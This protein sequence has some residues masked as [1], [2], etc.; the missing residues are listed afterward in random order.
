VDGIRMGKAEWYRDWVV[1][2][3]VYI[4]AILDGEIR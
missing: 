2:C 3:F 1:I 4:F